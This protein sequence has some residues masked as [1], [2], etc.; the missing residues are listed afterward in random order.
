MVTMC[1]W[2]DHTERVPTNM[3]GCEDEKLFES[4]LAKCLRSLASPTNGN[5]GPSATQVVASIV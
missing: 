3:E 5:H 4:A 2:A 1:C